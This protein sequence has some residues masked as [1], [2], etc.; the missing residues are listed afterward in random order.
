MMAN[1]DSRMGDM[2]ENAR[3]SKGRRGV[4]K[5]WRGLASIGLAAGSALLATTSGAF[6]QSNPCAVYGSG[7]VALNGTDTCVRIG[8]RVRVDGVVV[9][10]Q[11][12]FGSGGS[13]NFAPG[14]QN[15]L[16]GPDR[17]HLRLQGGASNT[18]PRTR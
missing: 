10:P 18:M 7:F 3:I 12:V 16:D 5:Q 15:G 17:A 11:E 13:Y 14:P 2:S 8:G 4:S 9:A 6:A 1:L